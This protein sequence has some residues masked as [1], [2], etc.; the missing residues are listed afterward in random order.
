MCCINWLIVGDDCLIIG[1]LFIV[2][3]LSL[4]GGGCYGLFVA[5]SYGDLLVSLYVLVLM[6]MLRCLGW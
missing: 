4:V 3:Q 2:L 5:G 6:L 1:V